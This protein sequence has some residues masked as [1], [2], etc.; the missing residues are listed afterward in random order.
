MKRKSIPV[1]E[2]SEITYDRTGAIKEETLTP[3]PWLRFLA[4][5]LDYSLWLT[6][7]GLTRFFLFK[8]HFAGGKGA[9][10]PWEF[11]AFFPIE[12][13]FLCIWGKTVGKH[14]LK[15]GIRQGKRGKL[16]LISSCRRSLSVWFRGV[17][18]MIPFFNC[19]CMLFAY[20]RLMSTK[21]TSWDLDEGIV[22]FYRPI[23]YSRV[24]VAG[25]FS[26]IT[27]LLYYGRGA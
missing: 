7:L 8:G 26:F 17:G 25:A 14:F 5:M 20:Y 21:V 12:A 15:I 16:S 2:P 19:I 4:R 3:H 6:L 9:L 18:M 11:I 10:V 23:G 1:L 24:F 13:A 27:F 22:V